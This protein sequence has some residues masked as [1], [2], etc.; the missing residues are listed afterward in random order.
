M[1][2]IVG[3]SLQNRGLSSHRT[4][5]IYWSVYTEINIVAG[6]SLQNRCLDGHSFGFYFHANEL[7]FCCLGLFL[8]RN[9][10][11]FHLIY[12]L[13]LY[14]FLFLW[15]FYAFSTYCL[16]LC[17]FIVW[18][19]LTI[20]SCLLF[21]VYGGFLH[22][23]L[24]MLYIS[25][26][27]ILVLL[28]L[29]LKV[30]YISSMFILILLCL[31]VESALYFQRV[32][33]CIALCLLVECALQFHCVYSCIALCLLVASSLHFYCL[34]VVNDPHFHLICLFI[35]CYMFVFCYFYLTVVR[36]FVFNKSVWS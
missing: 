11:L 16:F 5:H 9:A 14:G 3:K 10:Q 22:V 34:L 26:V 28:C 36:V 30:L 13:L 8:F 12:Y 6:K 20:P 35:Y 27:F 2:N 19:C 31:L 21:I 17:C 32:Y 7:W 33:S 24:K 29:L 25:I 4:H 15:K 1:I 18:K 23:C